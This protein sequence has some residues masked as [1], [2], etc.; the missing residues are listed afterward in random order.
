MV[1]SCW[2]KYSHVV[3][4][5]YLYTISSWTEKKIQKDVA[6]ITTFIV[7]KI[8][9]FQSNLPLLS[10]QAIFSA[11]GTALTFHDFLVQNVGALVAT[12]PTAATVNTG[13]PNYMASALVFYG[14]TSQQSQNL[15][16]V[17]NLEAEFCCCPKLGKQYKSGSWVLLLS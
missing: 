4:G 5:N 13:N 7:Q 8:V 2:S 11:K 3:V 15:D 9:S 1:D 12:G 14:E 10:F 17:Q 16:E 6:N